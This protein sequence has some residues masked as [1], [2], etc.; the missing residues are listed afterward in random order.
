[1]TDV[2][3]SQIRRKAFGQIFRHSILLC[4]VLEYTMLM[5]DEYWGNFP[6]E[7]LL[8]FLQAALFCAAL[9]TGPAPRQR[10]QKLLPRL[11]PVPLTAAV[12]IL[13]YVLLPGRLWLVS[14]R[15]LGTCLFA[16]G[17]LCWNR[18]RREPARPLL[19]MYACAVSLHLCYLPLPIVTA[20][21]DIPALWISRYV[22]AAILTLLLALCP[23][24]FSA[25]RKRKSSV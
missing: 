20:M 11:W 12:L 16:A 5:L 1:M 18:A 13:V 10:P 8:V 22:W 21:F 23:V 4:F 7:Y 17:A 25:G 2:I 24:F 6:I 14:S 19:N 15:V 3:R 9:K